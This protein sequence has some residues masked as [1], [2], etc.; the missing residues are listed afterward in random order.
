MSCAATCPGVQIG[1]AADQPDSIHR[2]LTSIALLGR[3]HQPMHMRIFNMDKID[4]LQ[5]E[6]NRITELKASPL[7]PL[8]VLAVGSRVLTICDRLI[9]ASPRYQ[10]LSGLSCH[11]AGY[12]GE[13]TVHCG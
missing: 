2:D 4:A 13:K 10:L 5:F 8:A 12:S 7:T 1:T 6:S 9:A 3:S 11:A